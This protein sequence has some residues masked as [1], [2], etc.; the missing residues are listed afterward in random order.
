MDVDQEAIF[1]RENKTYFI[2]FE[3]R[4][5]SKFYD[6]LRKFWEIPLVKILNIKKDRNYPS[7]LIDLFLLYRIFCGKS[8]FLFLFRNTL[9]WVCGD[10]S[11]HLSFLDKID[12]HQYHNKNF[13]KHIT[14]SYLHDD[15][16]WDTFEIHIPKVLSMKSRP[17]ILTQ[18]G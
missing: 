2:I 16:E 3:K 6:V 8:L 10:I 12:N 14:P 1:S 4:K 7:A 18:N 11:P 15:R 5:K 9:F 17:D 13:S